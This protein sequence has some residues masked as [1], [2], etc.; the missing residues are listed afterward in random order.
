MSRKRKA[1]A[2]RGKPQTPKQKA[3]A[4]RAGK[5]K[6]RR[7]KEK[8]DKPAG[9]LDRVCPECKTKCVRCDVLLTSTNYTTATQRKQFTCN[10][11]VAEVV[12]NSRDKTKQR[13]YDLLRKYAITVNEYEELLAAQEGACWICKKVPGEGAKRLSVDHKHAKGEKKRNPREIRER[14]RGLLCWPCNKAIAYL[15]D[16]SENAIRAAEYLTKWPAQEILMKMKIGMMQNSDARIVFDEE[17][18]EKWYHTQIA[19]GNPLMKELH[20]AFRQL[21]EERNSDNGKV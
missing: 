10:A 20:N 16:E 19:D 4:L 21:F 17:A 2:A 15:R 5:R 3:A 9:T 18:L 6:C 13:E 7:C 11:C 8:F 12:R 14:V 1:N